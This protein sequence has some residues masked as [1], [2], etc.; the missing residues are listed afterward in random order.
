M[1]SD[2]TGGTSHPLFS[3]NTTRNTQPA[4]LPMYWQ[5]FSCFV[6]LYK[7]GTAR[8]LISL[9][10]NVT[11]SPSSNT[12]EVLRAVA[13]K[14]ASFVCHQNIL[15]LCKSNIFIVPFHNENKNSCTKQPPPEA[16]SHAFFFNITL[17]PWQCE[18]FLSMHVW[19]YS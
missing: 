18:I 12:S 16:F 1:N 13:L 19:C 6:F 8:P 4:F 5:S 7:F 11:V 14:N 2:F 9:S 15:T 17:F 10:C 3:E